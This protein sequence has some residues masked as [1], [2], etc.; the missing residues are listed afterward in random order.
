[1]PDGERWAGL[2]ETTPCGGEGPGRP[3]EGNSD[4]LYVAGEISR[5][6]VLAEA[7]RMHDAREASAALMSDFQPV[8]AAYPVLLRRFATALERC[9]AR[10][11]LRRL[12][13]AAH[14]EPV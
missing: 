5:I 13:I 11:L 10:Q 14:G 1:M 9:E 2:R 3:A 8:L 7:E 6:M 12:T 4:L